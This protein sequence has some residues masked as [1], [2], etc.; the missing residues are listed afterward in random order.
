MG[1]IK[2]TQK[3]A[4][5]NCLSKSQHSSLKKKLKHIVTNWYFLNFSMK[6]VDRVHA[7]EFRIGREFKT[8]F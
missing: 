3:F 5:S 4:T 2:E 8:T 1:H 6:N 7:R